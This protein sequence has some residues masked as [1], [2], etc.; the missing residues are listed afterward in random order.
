MG[1]SSE[2]ERLTVNQKV[3]GSIPAFQ[4]ELCRQSINNLVNWCYS[5]HIKVVPPARAVPVA[6]QANRNPYGKIGVET[7]RLFK[8]SFRLQDGRVRFMSPYSQY[9]R[10]GSNPA[11][12][13]VCS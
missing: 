4:D 2:V 1:S 9:G 5:A 6:S 8:R 13:N 3:A 11:L 7:N 10:A 12:A